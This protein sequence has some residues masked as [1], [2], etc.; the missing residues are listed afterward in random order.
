MAIADPAVSEDSEEFKP[1]RWLDPKHAKSLAVHQLP[2]GAGQHYCLGSHLATAELTAAVAVL[3]RGYELQA[4][5]H[6]VWVD[7]PIKKPSKFFGVKLIS[8]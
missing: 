6:V 7:F 2:F 8:V 4:D 3:A 1:E 5:M